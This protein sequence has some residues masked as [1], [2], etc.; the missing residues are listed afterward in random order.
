M[1]R[2]KAAHAQKSGK[3]AA[4]GATHRRGLDAAGL[5]PGQSPS[6]PS[7]E[8][9]G[10][11]ATVTMRCARRAQVQGARRA[12]AAHAPWARVAK[13]QT[14]RPPARPRRPEMPPAPLCR[15]RPASGVPR[16]WA[17]ASARRQKAAEATKRMQ[18]LAFSAQEAQPRP[19]RPDAARVQ[20]A[21]RAE[22]ARRRGGSARARARLRGGRQGRRRAA[23]A[24][25]GPAARAATRRST[26]QRRAR[27]LERRASALPC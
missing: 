2:G 9:R 18:R 26:T 4:K 16:W 24:G 3:K 15:P 14:Q 5:L 19:S 6:T 17:R 11:A 12:E 27:R 10:A 25:R 13:P 20:A 21:A 7:V 8:P 1:R 22:A 23:A